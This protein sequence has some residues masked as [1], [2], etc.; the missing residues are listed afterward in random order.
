VIT[1]AQLRS[2]R[3]Q[4]DDAREMAR[5]RA[6]FAQVRVARRPFLLTAAEFDDVLRWKLRGQ[7]VRQR[8]LREGNTEAL[9][10]MLTQT[11]CALKHSDPEYELE[12]RFGLLGTLRGVGVPVASAV[13]GLVFPQNYAVIDYRGWRQIMGDEQSAFSL[14]DYKRYL[15]AVSELATELAW[16]LPTVDVALWEID[17][18]QGAPVTDEAD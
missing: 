3:D 2:L 8:G 5:L 15:A 6:R 17:R 14:P 12:L 9:I 18:R 11:A 1:A 16:D 4:G 7:F 10:R 13:L